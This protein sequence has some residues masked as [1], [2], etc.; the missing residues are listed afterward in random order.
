MKV[1]GETSCSLDW[2]GSQKFAGLT[3]G[4]VKGENMRNSF[5]WSCHRDAHEPHTQPQTSV[6]RQKTAGV[7]VSN[8]EY[9]AG[10]C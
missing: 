7:N 5:L 6:Q 3:P 2:V 8:C 4:P 9:E 1:L 10:C